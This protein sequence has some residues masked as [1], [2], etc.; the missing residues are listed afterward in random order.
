MRSDALIRRNAIID[1]ACEAI[2][3]NKFG[4]TLEEIAVNANVGVA[5]LYR[6]FP[7]RKELTD[8]ALEKLLHSSADQ[9]SEIHNTLK[10]EG[11]E[12]A[13]AAIDKV[14][15]LIFHLGTNVLGPDILHPILATDDSF[16][17]PRGRVVDALKSLDT[18]FRDAGVIH[19]SINGLDFFNGV[20]ALCGQPNLEQYESDQTTRDK[21]V[22]IYLAGCRAGIQP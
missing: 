8:A 19:E 13:E 4:F 21:L 14:V 17:E 1:A 3:T 7:N 5:T 10:A 11:P 20:I 18:L 15:Q 16:S 2:I 22:A 12:G 9:L 6:N